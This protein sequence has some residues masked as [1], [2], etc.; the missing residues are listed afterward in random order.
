[1]INSFYGRTGLSR[2]TDT[3]SLEYDDDVGDLVFKASFNPD[4]DIEDSYIPYAC[5][6]TAYARARLLQNMKACLEQY[7]DSIIHC[8]TDSVVHFGPPIKKIPHGEHLGT[9]GIESV[10][11]VCIE[12]GFKRYW[13]CR[14]Y[15]MTSKDDFISC[16]LAGVPQHYTDDGVPIGM[17]VEIWD[18]PKV[19]LEDGHALGR[20]D[21]VIKSDWLRKLY[22]EHGLDPDHVNT[23]KLIPRRVPGGV[24]LEER[25]HQLNDNLQWRFRR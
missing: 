10:P 13:E 9:W 18:E 14:Q 23:F 15:P 3:V 8:D 24:I 19:I 2:D 17:W 16:A 12:S 1:M 21:Y 5:F 22:I 11:P 4:E 6:A 7:E 20:S 25:Q